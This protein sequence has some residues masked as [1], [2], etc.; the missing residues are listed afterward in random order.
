MEYENVGRTVIIP[1]CRSPCSIPIPDIWN[2]A[3]RSDAAAQRCGNVLL[4]ISSVI[5]KYQANQGRGDLNISN[6]SWYYE[7]KYGRDLPFYTIG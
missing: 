6:F 7:L 2:A 5:I 4:N 3:V 1:T